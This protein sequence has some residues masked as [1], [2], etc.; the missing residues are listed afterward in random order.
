[1]ASL[2][3][4]APTAGGTPAES[5]GMP[6]ELNRMQEVLAMAAPVL[7]G[8]HHADL[9][10][11]AQDMVISQGQEIRQMDD[12]LEKWYGVSRAY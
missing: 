8:G 1:M 5:T 3:V 6:L 12:W 9:H 7:V 11:L 4:G 10:R 2:P